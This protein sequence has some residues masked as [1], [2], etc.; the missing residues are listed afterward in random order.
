M[1]DSLLILNGPGLDQLGRVD[2]HLY[3][4]ATL[5]D[6]KRICDSACA[7]NGFACD[8]RQ[9]NETGQ[10]L[11]WIVAARETHIGIIINPAIGTGH[12]YEVKEAYLAIMHGLKHIK[13]PTI[14]VHL[15]NLF[16]QHAEPRVAYDS[17]V[18]LG[19]ICGFGIRGYALAIKGMRSATTRRADKS[20]PRSG[21][22]RPN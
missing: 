6:V 5:G 16:A 17:T 18:S 2:L 11:E 10:L 22:P 9:S 8:F 7:E 19:L 3:G 12:E 4:S 15:T 13:L 1:T 14:E 20:V 21:H